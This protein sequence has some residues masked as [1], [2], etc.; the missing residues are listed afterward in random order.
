MTDEP[1]LIRY[2]EQAHVAAAA[3]PMTPRQPVPG[4]SVELLREVGAQSAAGIHAA[5]PAAHLNAEDRTAWPAC[6]R[7]ALHAVELCRRAAEL[8]ARR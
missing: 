6:W 4:D 8:A 7:Q 2:N 1:A 3:A 5:T